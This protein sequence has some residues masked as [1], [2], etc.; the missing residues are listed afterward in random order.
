LHLP[1]H[2]AG[3][4]KTAVAHVSSAYLKRNLAMGNRDEP[5]AK[6]LNQKRQIF[7]LSYD[8]ISTVRL[9]TAE[10]GHIALT[11]LYLEVA[12]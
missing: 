9:G 5:V 10:S 7:R 11:F 4:K 12:R 3:E 6:D 1:P 8:D 2:P